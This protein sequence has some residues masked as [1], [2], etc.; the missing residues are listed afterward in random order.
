MHPSLAGSG[1]LLVHA[2]A[3]RLGSVSELDDLDLD[4][5]MASAVTVVEWGEG[6]AEGL[7]EDRLE[8]SIEPD[9]GSRDAH[10]P[11]ERPWPALECGAHE[12]R[13]SFIVPLYRSRS[14]IAPLRTVSLPEACRARAGI[15]AAVG[16]SAHGRPG[17]G[18][19]GRRTTRRPSRR[20]SRAAGPGEAPPAGGGARLI[21]AAV[22]VVIAG[23]V[24]AAVL[25]PGSPAPAPV[26]PGSLIT[27][28]Q[29]GELQAVPN[30]C[31]SIPAATVTRNLQG[32]AKVAAPLQVG[33]SAQSVCDWT[34]DQPPV[35]RLLQLDLLAYA[36][37]GL[38]SGDGSATNAAIDAYT[39]GGA[40]PARIRPGIRPIPG[41]RSPR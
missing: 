1:P 3:Y 6:L 38:A 18:C 21:T 33:G 30:A 26:T 15:P 5:D 39:P 31:Q 7:A 4:A 34:V 10:G 27:T 37:N 32:P 14:P 9:P 20:G 12:Q 23:G 17:V 8:I 16:R 22:L 11:A 35:Y 29:P 28:F 2:D 41:R 40:G 24:T 36:P 19:P 13:R 25:L